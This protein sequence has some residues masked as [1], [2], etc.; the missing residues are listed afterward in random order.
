MFKALFLTVDE[1]EP[2]QL[3]TGTD[4][5]PKEQEPNPR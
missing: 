1:E 2:L 3:E 5:E 4:Q